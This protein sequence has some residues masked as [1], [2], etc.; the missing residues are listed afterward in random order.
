MFHSFDKCRCLKVYWI[1]SC[2]FLLN[3][4]SQRKTCERE[5]RLCFCSINFVASSSPNCYFMRTTVSTM[6]TKIDLGTVWLCRIFHSSTLSLILDIVLV[7]QEYQ[8]KNQ[9]HRFKPQLG[10]ETYGYIFNA[11]RYWWY[12]YLLQNFKNLVDAIDIYRCYPSEVEM[13]EF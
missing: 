9:K 4:E 6:E 7:S 2:N 12:Y 13:D 8:V 11:P 10:E 5:S 1:Q 3:Q